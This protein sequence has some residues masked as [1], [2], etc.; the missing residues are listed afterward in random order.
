MSIVATKVLEARTSSTIGVLDKHEHR[1]G[2]YGAVELAKNDTQNVVPAATIEANRLSETRPQSMAVYKRMEKTIGTGGAVCDPATEEPETALVPV[3]W[4]KLNFTITQVDTRFAANEVLKQQDFNHQLEA[5]IRGGLEKLSTD[6]IAAIETSKSQVLLNDMASVIP[7]NGATNQLEIA[8]TGVAR[9]EA[10]SYTNSIMAQNSFK[11]R[12]NFL[13][14][15]G[16]NPIADYYT[17]QGAQ[18]ATNTSYQFGTYNMYRDNKV[19]AGAGNIGAFYVMPMGSISIVFWTNLQARIGSDAG[20][21]GQI[22]DA[23]VTNIPG[24]GEMAHFTHRKCITDATYDPG[25]ELAFQTVDQFEL[26]YAIITNYNS[27]IATIADPKV[28]GVFTA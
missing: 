13:H 18:N 21:A 1:Q 27:S 2:E 9:Q 24:L 20:G 7:F 17:N 14:S 6:V 5:G 4:N 11:G 23:G 12:L 3:T 28:K 10:W 16:I 15:Y 19:I 25:V 8:S 26:Q 22:I